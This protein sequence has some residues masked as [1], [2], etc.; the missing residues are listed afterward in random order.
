MGGFLR[1]R[2][3]I[4]NCIS[5]VKDFFF[6]PL[7]FSCNNRLADTESRVCLTCWQSIEKIHPDD[8]TVHVMRERF[9]EDGTI[10]EFYSCYYFQ[11]GGVFQKLV[12]SLKY[13]AITKFGIELGEHVG[14]MMKAQTDVCAIDA[15]VPVP[16]YKLKQR[17]RGYNQSESLCQG[18]AQVLLRPVALS[19]VKRLKNTVSQTHLSAEERNQNVGD[20]F[21]VSPLKRHL[22]QG[23]TLLIVDDVITTGSTIQSVARVLKSAGAARV[24]AASAAIAKLDSN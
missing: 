16:L 4:A 23:K 11:E 7:C 14:A 3:F 9:L 20:A 5:P 17:E 12:H 21:E 8:Y 13:D 18:I 10:D 1:T 15:L 6:P 2:S 19:L 24:I 22:V